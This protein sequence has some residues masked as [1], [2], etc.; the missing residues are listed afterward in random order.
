V[1]TE[2][3]K[4]RLIPLCELI[5][6]ARVDT[7]VHAFYTKLRQDAD[8]K[9]YFAHIPDFAEHEA[10]IADFWW[11]AMGGKVEKRHAVDMVRR[12]Q[13][14]GLDEQAFA[15]WL[16]V[17]DQTTHEHLPTDLA[18]AWLRMAQAI[19]ANLK[20]ILLSPRTHPSH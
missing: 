18:D 19:G 10:H 8:L 9:R 5:G 20:R 4:R 1:E 12:H 13:P 6:R 16:A 7:V 3:P 14:L 15:R 17:F 11:I 2:Q